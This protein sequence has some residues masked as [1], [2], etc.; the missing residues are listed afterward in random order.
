M[1]G[2]MV[3]T[4]VRSGLIAAVIWSGD[5]LAQTSAT[6]SSSFAY[7]P[8]SGLLTQE[9]IEPNTPA[10]RLQTDYTYDAFGNKLTTT[11][12]GADIA[13]RAA[14][15]TYDSQGRF[16][17][18][19]TNAVGQ[20]ESWQD[21]PR[22]GK[23]TSHTGPNGLTTTWSYDGFGRKI[24]EV[25][26]DGTQTK[27]SYQFCNGVNGGTASCVAGAIYRVQATPLAADGTT[28]NGPTGIVYLDS[29]TSPATPGVLTAAP[30]A[31][32][33]SMTASGASSSRAG[34]ISPP[35]APRSL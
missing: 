10:L 20:S 1:S 4:V 2:S 7:D 22:F 11:A 6:R 8:S 34:R 9:V 31:P 26:P 16:A 5:A 21:D 32:P 30:C 12:S 33:S 35:A 28:P 24:L 17:T 15:A 14:S 27:W 19:A 13:T 29:A 23:P 25:R 18:S 3:R